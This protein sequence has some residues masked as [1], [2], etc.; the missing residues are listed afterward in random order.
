M[1]QDVYSKFTPEEQRGFDACQ[2]PAEIAAYLS[3]LHG[4]APEAERDGQGRFVARGQA[5]QTPE[6]VA[7][8]AAADAARA[9]AAGPK[10]FKQTVQIAGQDFE[11]TATSAEA[12]Q[13][14][15]ESA[16]I[17]AE[18][19]TT[20]RAAE[21]RAATHSAAQDV[22]DAADAEIALRT[23]TITTAQYLERTHA[24]EDALAAK[25]VNLA[26]VSGEQLSQDWAQAGAE[27]RNS[28]A[29]ESWP[30]GTKNQELIGLEVVAMGLVDAEDKVAALAQAYENLKRKGLLFEGDHDAQEMNDL[31]VNSGATPAEILQAWKDA[32]GITNGDATRANEVWIE[33]FKNGRSSSI[34]GK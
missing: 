8:K 21:T 10:E 3:S 14:Q 26:R 15:I 11:F 33:T 24:I 23:G 7:A 30:G 17:V 28:P 31:A 6:E 19:L 20:A 25:G 22:V 34:F 12:L 1:A 4:P 27:F 13:L 9:A 5:T 2:T 32:Q 18:Q 16:R 29:G